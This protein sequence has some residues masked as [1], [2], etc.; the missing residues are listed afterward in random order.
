MQSLQFNFIGL[1]G[2]KAR[3]KIGSPTT[4]VDWQQALGCGTPIS[5]DSGY[6]HLGVSTIWCASFMGFTG[7]GTSFDE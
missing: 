4:A 1:V 6:P 5:R 3:K 2:I 7:G